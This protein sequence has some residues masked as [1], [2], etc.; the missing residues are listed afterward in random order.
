MTIAASP[1]SFAATEGADRGGPPS[2]GPAA[3]T[4]CD[5]RGTPDWPTLLTPIHP[6]SVCESAYLHAT[7]YREPVQATSLPYVSSQWKSGVSGPSWSTP[8]ASRTIIA[9]VSE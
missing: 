5:A 6:G 4:L 2:A 9:V 7:T 3:A 8:A 1:E